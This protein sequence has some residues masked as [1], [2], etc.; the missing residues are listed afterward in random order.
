M[1]QLAPA[2][3]DLAA[4]PAPRR[5]PL[6]L[7]IGLAVPVPDPVADLLPQARPGVRPHITLVHT[8]A[9][10]YQLWSVRDAVDGR[11]HSESL[12]GLDPFDVRLS[13][14]GDFRRDASVMPVVYLQVDDGADRLASLAASLDA[15][16]GLPRRFPFTPHVTLASWVDDDELDQIADRYRHFEAAFLVREL[17]F[18]RASGTIL[19]P[20]RITRHQPQT[21]PLL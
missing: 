11:M 19:S 16:F 15:E 12:S 14:V 8:Q 6:G 5:E 10:P 3:A 4:A 17:T 20:R 9:S 1:S 18:T 21:Y 13:G 7:Y 2:A